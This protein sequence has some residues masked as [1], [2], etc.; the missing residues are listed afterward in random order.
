M[1]GMAASAPEKVRSDSLGTISRSPS[2]GTGDYFFPGV[3]LQ[4]EHLSSVSLHKHK[5][6]TTSISK[7][8]LLPISFVPCN[9]TTTTSISFLISGLGD[10]HWST[11]LATTSIQFSQ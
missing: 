1:G 5:F 10:F 6:A 4:H 2:Q 7:I 3:A 11:P 8:V 9:E